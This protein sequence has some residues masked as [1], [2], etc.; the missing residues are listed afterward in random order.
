MQVKRHGLAAPSYHYQEDC[1]I[2][3]RKESTCKREIT[4]QTLLDIRLGH[5]RRGPFLPNEDDEHT[6]NCQLMCVHLWL[7]ML[8]ILLL[9]IDALAGLMDTTRSRRQHEVKQAFS[10]L[11]DIIAFMLN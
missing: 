10:T 1:L 6:V 9:M 8:K 3:L 7:G 4:N 11:L 5:E 2:K